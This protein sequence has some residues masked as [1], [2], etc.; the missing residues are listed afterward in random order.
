MAKHGVDWVGVLD[1]ER[2]LGWAWATRPRRRSTR[3]RRAASQRFAAWV[4]PDT[5]LRE[6]LD[7]IVDSRT[8]VAVVLDDDD[9]YLGMLTIDA[10]RRG[11]GRVSRRRARR[12]RPRLVHLVGLGRSTTSTTSGTRTVE[13]LRLTLIAVGDRLR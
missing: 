5:A 12:E 13:H 8:R 1:G 11:D 6:A 2:L 9:R 7:V 4:Q 3:G 10:D